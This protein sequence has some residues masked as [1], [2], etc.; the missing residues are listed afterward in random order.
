MDLRPKNP[1]P[2][3]NLASVMSRAGHAEEALPLAIRALQVPPANPMVLDTYAAVL[4]AVGR[5]KEA[6]AAQLQAV[7][8]IA[9]L[10]THDRDYDDRLAEY[11]KACG[12]E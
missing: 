8:S 11:E 7:E 10:T 3:N 5:C 4:Y 1:L 6:L 9:Q 12:A 2:L